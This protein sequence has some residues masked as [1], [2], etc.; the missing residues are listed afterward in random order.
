LRFRIEGKSKISLFLY[1][2]DYLIVE[3]FNDEAVVADL[4]FD[5]TQYVIADILDLS[6]IDLINGKFKINLKPHS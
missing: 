1:D 2:N 6:V 3:N 4:V 5:E